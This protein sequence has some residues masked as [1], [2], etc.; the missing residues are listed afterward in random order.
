MD[1]SQQIKERIQFLKAEKDK[2]NCEL[3]EYQDRMEGY[4]NYIPK[5]DEI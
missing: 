3:K 2:I 5:G 4:E 1:T